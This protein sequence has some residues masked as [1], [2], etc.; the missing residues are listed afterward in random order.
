MPRRFFDLAAQQQAQALFNTGLSV[1]EIAQRLHWSVP[2]IQRA[3]QIAPKH[4]GKS[5]K[6][7][8]RQTYER[9]LR[10]FELGLSKR[11]IARTLGIHINTVRKYVPKV[12]RVIPA[13]E[14]GLGEEI[15]IR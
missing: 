5:T 4:T 10:L 6:Q 12:S 1:W 14:D 7:I 9:I 11:G 3:L 15:R 2:T 8:S 13:P